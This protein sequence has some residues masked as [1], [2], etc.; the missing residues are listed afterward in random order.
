MGGWGEGR[1]EGR[2]R[3][4]GW[5][6]GKEGGGEG[7][8]VLVIISAGCTC[9]PQPVIIILKKGPLSELISCQGLVWRN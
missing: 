5:E 4:G 6:E 8:I 7:D 9:C 3:E 2:G 1:R